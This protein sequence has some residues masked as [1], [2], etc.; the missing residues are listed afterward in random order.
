MKMKQLFGE[1]SGKD[2]IETGDEVSI[3]YY[4]G[5]KKKTFK[6]IL[7]EADEQKIKINRKTIEVQDILKVEKLY[8]SK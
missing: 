7:I 8:K 4:D 2:L 1:I 3:T 6:G 5:A